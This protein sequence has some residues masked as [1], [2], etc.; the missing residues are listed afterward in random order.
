MIPCCL[1]SCSFV[2][3]VMKIVWQ[4]RSGLLPASRNGWTSETYIGYNCVNWGNNKTWPSSK[5]ESTPEKYS[6]FR[7]LRKYKISFVHCLKTEE[8]KVVK[9]SGN[10]CYLIIMYQRK[11]KFIYC[12][13]AFLH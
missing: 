4:A 1:S 10:Y 3:M 7:T 8:V 5:L 12:F 11:F 9:F 6:D 13:S 2:E